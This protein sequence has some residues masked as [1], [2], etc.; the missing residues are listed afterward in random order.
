MIRD[1]LDLLKGEKDAELRLIIPADLPVNDTKQS[2]RITH[3]MTDDDEAEASQGQAR[4][5]S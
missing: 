2:G 4:A 5:A 3:P 1:V